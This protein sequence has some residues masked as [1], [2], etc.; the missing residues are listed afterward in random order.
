MQLLKFYADWCQP[1]KNLSAV[2]SN[3][4]IP[5]KV[6]EIDVDKNMEDTIFYG[7]RTLPTLVLLDENNNV[8][9]KLTGSVTE[10]HFKQVFNLE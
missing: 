6:V 4:D 9:K 2:M 10:L 3:I 5:W 8:V 1:C 7:V